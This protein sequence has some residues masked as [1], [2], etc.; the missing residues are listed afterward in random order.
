MAC[1]PHTVALLLLVE[2]DGVAGGSPSMNRWLSECA[3]G[4]SI[5]RIG[6]AQLF[7]IRISGPQMHLNEGSDATEAFIIC[8][9]VCARGGMPLPRRTRF[10]QPSQSDRVNSGY[11]KPH[12]MLVVNSSTSIHAAFLWVTVFGNDSKLLFVGCAILAATTCLLVDS[13]GMVLLV[14]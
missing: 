14:R 13:L 11:S 2:V 10:R 9:L 12:S 5:F 1:Y 8:A 3:P 6:C 4:L 7:K